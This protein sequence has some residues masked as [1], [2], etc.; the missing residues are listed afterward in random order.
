MPFT[1]GHKINVGRRCSEATKKKIGKAKSNK[2]IVVCCN[3]GCG[4]RF[5]RTPSQLDRRKSQ[6][7]YCSKQCMSEA[8]KGRRAWNKGM[9]GYLEGVKKWDGLAGEENPRWKGSN[10]S[11]RSLHNWVVYHLG[12]AIKCTEC[13]LDETPEGKKRY[14]DWAN[15]SGE[16][17]RDLEDWK[18]L[19]KLCHKAFDKRNKEILC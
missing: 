17:K 1:K 11:Y 19:C 6:K 14:F 4:E 13:G 15:I 16:Y 18:Q 3:D 2:I 12:R 7:V 9:K 5:G 10:I 8:F